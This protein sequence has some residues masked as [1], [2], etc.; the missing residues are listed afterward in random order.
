VRFTLPLCFAGLAA[1]FAFVLA[2]AASA[3]L[4]PASPVPVG[5]LRS[6]VDHYRTVTW[7]YERA[8]HER[9]TPTSFSDRRSTDRGYLEW[10]I[11]TWTRRSYRA[12][13]Q[14]LARIHR[15][16]KVSL[17]PAPTVHGRLSDRVSYSRTLALRLR[18]LYPGHVS[19]TFAS[20][21]GGN[22]RQTLRLWQARSAAA[23][24]EVSRRGVEIAYPIPASL[25]ESFMCIHRFEGAWVSHTGNGYYGGLQ[26]DRPFQRHY[27][28][29]FLARWGTADNWPVWAQLTAAV[30]AYRS[31]RGFTPWPNTARACRL[32]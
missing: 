7:T 32:L 18:K 11:D 14:A 4:A 13:S 10:T 28:R 6:I 29:E 20:A 23:T 16:L 27:G 22:G 17:P 9:R 5:A 12:R 31:G 8:A 24:L 25:R 3:H 21:R 26:M 1:S 19:R 15:I 30:R 2:G